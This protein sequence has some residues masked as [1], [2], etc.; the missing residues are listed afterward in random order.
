MKTKQEIV[1]DWLPRYTG[2]PL[3][4]FDDYILLTNFGHYVELF[5]KWNDAPIF[6]EGHNMPIAVPKALPSLILVWG[7]PM[8]RPSWI[9]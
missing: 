3:D 2:R 1:E 5:S 6:G 9:F 4:Q 7:V 8:R